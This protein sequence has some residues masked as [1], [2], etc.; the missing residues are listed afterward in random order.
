MSATAAASRREH[1][2]GALQCDER[3]GLSTVVGV[4]EEGPCAKAISELLEG[5]AHGDAKHC[6][7][8]DGPLSDRADSCRT[9]RERRQA[10][11]HTEPRPRP[12]AVRP[13]QRRPAGT[14]RV[15]D[16]VVLAAGTPVPRI[17]RSER[18]RDGSSGPPRAPEIPAPLRP[19]D[20]DDGTEERGHRHVLLED[21]PSRERR[22][23]PRACVVDWK[24]AER[25]GEVR[26]AHL[27]V[28]LS[29]VRPPVRGSR[30]CERPAPSVSR[31][32]GARG[33]ARALRGHR[34]SIAGTRAGAR[35]VVL[36]RRRL[37]LVRGPAGSRRVRPRLRGSRPPSAVVHGNV[38]GSRAHRRHGRTRTPGS[39]GFPGISWA[40]RREG[41]SMAE[42]RSPHTCLD[43][44]DSRPL[45]WPSSSRA[46]AAAAATR[47]RETAAPRATTTAAAEARAGAAAE[48]AAGAA[49][50]AA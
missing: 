29:P 50:A 13:R 8:V 1:V 47:V 49:E 30:R 45:S 12:S 6:V 20:G 48:A 28:R 2:V 31:L 37:R 34:G 10:T 9:P 22:A 7:R 18:V 11:S 4:K 46:A 3:R 21:R 26:R 14:L 43:R 32:R 23:S 42:A 35:E 36:R 25:R 15:F 39:K 38:A 24:V 41:A 17:R 40:P 19:R 5:R 44:S 33:R 16:C 27:P